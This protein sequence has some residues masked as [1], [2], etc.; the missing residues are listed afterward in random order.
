MKYYDLIYEKNSNFC[1]KRPNKLL[2]KIYKNLPK[3]VKFL[4]LGCGQ[5][6]DAFFMADKKF[7]VTAIDSS[8]VAIKQIKE[9]VKKKEYRNLKAICQNIKNF[10]IKPKKFFAINSANSLQFL[11]KKDSLDVINR[12]KKSV[13][14]GGFVMIASFTDKNPPSKR[15]RSH[16]EKNEMKKIFSDFKIIYYF[17]GAMAD[18]GHIG[19][20]EPHKHGIVKIIAQKLN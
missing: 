5:G 17:E 15:R 12:I 18:K 1:G 7:N 20:P 14:P 19:Q 10:T 16:F 2:L 4:D 13:L 9:E 3:K 11:N 6:K 8:R